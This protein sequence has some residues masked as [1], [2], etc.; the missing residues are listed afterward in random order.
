M[1]LDTDKKKIKIKY[2]QKIQIHKVP[3]GKGYQ[4]KEITIPKDLIKYWSK[5]IKQYKEENNE[6]YT[7]NEELKHLCYIELEEYKFITPIV[8]ETKDDIKINSLDPDLTNINTKIKQ[9]KKLPIRY[10]G[11]LYHIRINKGLSITNSKEYVD[12][13][14]NPYLIDPVTGYFGLCVIDGVKCE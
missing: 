13:I 2:H 1:I 6:S 4:Y 5:I 8:P 9:F 10:R 12:L 14:I 3:T 11:N 7:E